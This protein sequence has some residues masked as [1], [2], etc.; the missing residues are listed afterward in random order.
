MQAWMHNVPEAIIQS[1]AALRAQIPDLAERFARIDQYVR[2][3]VAAIRAEQAAGGAV[4]TLQFA[5]VQAGA[6]TEAQRQQIRRRG[7]AVV[8]GVFD[9]Q[10]IVQWNDEIGRYIEAVDYMGQVQSKAGLDQYF[11]ALASGAPQIFSLY[12]SKPQMQ[13]RQ[14]PNLARTRSFLNR[15]WQFDG[16]NGAVFDPDREC[17]YADRLRRRAPG[18]ASLG[19]S[20][21]ADAG[22]VERWCEPTFH[23][24]YREVFFG[25]VLAYD[26]FQAQGRDQTHEI[27]SPAV[28][29]LFRTFQ[30]WTALSR[31]GP[32]DGT[33][34][35][36]PIA[37][38]MAWMLLRALLDDVPADDLCGAQPGRALS[39]SA[40]WHAT[41]LEGEVSIPV[42]EPGDTV[43]WHS[44]TIHSVEDQ[45]RGSGYS[46]VI[47]IGA[48]PY[49][50]KN[51]AFLPKQ[52]E[53]FLQGRSSPDFAAENYELGFAGRATE[54]DLSE[55][56]KRQM[57]LQPW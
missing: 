45:H 7:C 47:Y 2:T 41:L 18:A 23:A 4:P 19:L 32:G 57:G 40:Q 52:A 9:P 17:T 12:W 8:R 38:G 13:A 36:V 3:E 11:S 43:W 27:P 49:C 42:V 48:A 5:D 33:L 28:A 21:H 31:Q 30:G 53:A 44:D 20:P 26:P 14:H 10:Q 15:L 35:L 56:G 55:L 29:S 22:S 39:A 51:A 50:A 6:I 46:N 37:K 1:K 25:D 54:A 16:P 24:V 34:K